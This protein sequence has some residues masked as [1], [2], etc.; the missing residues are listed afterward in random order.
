MFG[1]R[2]ISF[3]PELAE[4]ENI[5][6]MPLQVGTYEEYID[7]QHAIVKDK[8]DMEHYVTVCSFV[9]R[10]LLVVGC[11][12]LL[13]NKVNSLNTFKSIHFNY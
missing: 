13:H 12:V 8:S 3:K 11:N 2:C 10:D 4:L 1:S 6:G 5:R 7:D 9:D